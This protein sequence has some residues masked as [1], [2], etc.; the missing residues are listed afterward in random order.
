MEN[1]ES[2]LNA[3]YRLRE[4]DGYTK[5][6]ELVLLVK[7]GYIDEIAKI[8]ESDDDEIYFNFPNAIA[9]Y[10]ETVEIT[11]IYL[12]KYKE[13][14]SEKFDLLRCCISENNKACIE[15]ILKNNPVFHVAA[16]NFAMDECPLKI[17]SIYSYLFRAVDKYTDNEFCTLLKKIIIQDDLFVSYFYGLYDYKKELINTKDVIE[18]RKK[19]LKTKFELGIESLES[20]TDFKENPFFDDIRL[21]NSLSKLEKPNFFNDCLLHTRAIPVLD[22]LFELGFDV[23]SCYYSNATEI[24]IFNDGI[25]EY[26]YT[27][28][29]ANIDY[30][31]M[32]ALMDDND[33]SEQDI[34]DKVFNTA[35]KYRCLPDHIKFTDIK[36]KILFNLKIKLK[37]LREPKQATQ[38]KVNK[39]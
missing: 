24:H 26:F 19:I 4:S 36:E 18:L 21:F 30:S 29:R 31:L 11:K 5:N 14:N 7:L 25:A 12:E 13:N 38:K 1:K 3:L 17:F 33:F 16:Q 2:L 32:A 15:Y 20:D 35:I 28:P 9:I 34:K 39:I 37:S 27:L 8:L 23:A 10:D 6:Q 22:W